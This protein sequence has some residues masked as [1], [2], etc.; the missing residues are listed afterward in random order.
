M[1]NYKIFQ[2]GNVDYTSLIKSPDYD[3]NIENITETWV[4]GN[5]VNHTSIIRTRITGTVRM[6]LNKTQ[7]Q[8][9]LTDLETAKTAPGIYTLGV[10][11][12]NSTTATELTTI[13]AYTILENEVVY[14]TPGYGHK[15]YGMDVTLTLEE[16]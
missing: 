15:P 13:S 3:V 1:A 2:I 5:Y 16:I 4:D 14:G 10:H 8:Q 9:L 7:Y 6:V 11:I 12:N